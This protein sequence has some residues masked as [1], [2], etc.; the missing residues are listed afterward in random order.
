MPMPARKPPA[1]LKP[2]ARRDFRAILAYTSKRCGVAQRDT[3][4]GVIDR[5]YETLRAN[6]Q[7]GPAQD[8]ISP[9]LRSY[10]VEQHVIYYRVSAGGMTVVRILHGKMDAAR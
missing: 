10:L 3:Y 1:V 8:D 6:P 2:A 9:C 7:I 5:A 4:R